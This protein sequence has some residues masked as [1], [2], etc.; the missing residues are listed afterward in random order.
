MPRFEKFQC[1]EVISG[2]CIMMKVMT[3]EIF[4]GLI[5]RKKKRFIPSSGKRLLIRCSVT[6]KFFGA[7]LFR[8]NK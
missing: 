5:L 4:Y 7:D 8:R 6:E 1:G 2:V 3:Q